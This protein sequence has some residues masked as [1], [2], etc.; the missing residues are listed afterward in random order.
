MLHPTLKNAHGNI[1]SSRGFN[2]LRQITSRNYSI[3]ICKNHCICKSQITNILTSNNTSA[4]FSSFYA[5]QSSQI[6]SQLNLGAHI[7]YSTVSKP[8]VIKE[9]IIDGVF[10]DRKRVHGDFEVYDVGD[11]HLPEH[12]K[13]QLFNSDQRTKSI[14]LNQPYEPVTR[15]QKLNPDDYTMEDMNELRERG[16]RT[17]VEDQDYYKRKYSNIETQDILQ[18]GITVEM[19]ILPQIIPDKPFDQMSAGEFKSYASEHLTRRFMSSKVKI[20]KPRVNSDGIMYE[21]AIMNATALEVDD[22]LLKSKK[23]HENIKE[24]LKS[25][26]IDDVSRAEWEAVLSLEEQL[27]RLIEDEDKIY[28]PL[29]PKGLPISRIITIC[30]SLFIFCFFLLSIATPGTRALVWKPLISKLKGTETATSTN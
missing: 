7:N 24:R 2:I 17:N 13:Q 29:K 14:L 6:I 19:P 22:L 26:P 15:D 4:S 20:P 5:S 30:G 28:E 27:K 25:K 1:R 9:E 18:Q 11:K 21:E 23:E 8:Y 16:V 10:S 12:Q 3:S